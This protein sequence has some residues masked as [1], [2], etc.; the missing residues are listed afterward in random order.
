MGKPAMRRSVERTPTPMPEHP[1]LDSYRTYCVDADEQ[2]IW[3]SGIQADCLDE[4]LAEA[5]RACAD[6]DRPDLQVEVWLG[7]ELVYPPVGDR[8]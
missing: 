7:E 2:I 4:A 6:L 3:G 8:H 1:R 5:W